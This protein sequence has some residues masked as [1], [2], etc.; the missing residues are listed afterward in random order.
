M[1]VEARSE[2]FHHLAHLEMGGPFLNRKMQQLK[3]S[4]GDKIVQR[5]ALLSSFKRASRGNGSILEEKL[6]GV[7][8]DL[9]RVEK[10]F[11]RNCLS[12][13]TST[14]WYLAS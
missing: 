6:R 2:Q 11:S 13:Q 8:E 7:R 1:F 10:T 14:C 4:S 9:P 5:G 12:L 3:V